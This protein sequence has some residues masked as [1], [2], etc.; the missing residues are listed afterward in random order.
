[1]KIK[2]LEYINIFGLVLTGLG[3]ISFGFA[4]AIE[5]VKLNVPVFPVVKD[6]FITGDIILVI[7]VALVFIGMILFSFDVIPSCDDLMEIETLKIRYVLGEI[8]KKQYDLMMK[9]IKGFHH[10]MS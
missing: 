7:S 6:L 1:M 3:S 5:S 2:I 4:F 9:E 10:T 8:S